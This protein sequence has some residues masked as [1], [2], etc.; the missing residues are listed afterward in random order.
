M[1]P[2]IAFNVALF[3]LLMAGIGAFTFSQRADVDVVTL[4]GVGVAAAFWAGVLVAF[5][6]GQSLDAEPKPRAI[7]AALLG[8]LAYVGLFFALT[9]LA[10]IEMRPSFIALGAAVGAV[11]HGLRSLRASQAYVEAG[12]DND[13]ADDG[14]ADVGGAD[15][16]QVP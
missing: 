2:R 7:R 14:G 4:V 15:D 13:G 6:E 9:T 10:G 3:G 1:L 12:V 5:S 16:E 8:A 11:S